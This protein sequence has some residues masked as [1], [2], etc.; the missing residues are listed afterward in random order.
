MKEL[1][2][3]SKNDINIISRLKHWSTLALVGV[4][5][6]VFIRLNFEHH[7]EGASYSWGWP[8]RLWGTGQALDYADPLQVVGAWFNLIVLVISEVALCAIWVA[9]QRWCR[10]RRAGK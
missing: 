8:C 4:V 5:L 2:P 1:N 10:G 6:A 9:L 3:S 7:Q